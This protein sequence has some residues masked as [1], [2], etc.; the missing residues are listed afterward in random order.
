MMM[1]LL[2][3][4]GQLRTERYRDT[5][6]GCQ[7]PAVQ[8]KITDDVRR[9]RRSQLKTHVVQFH[10]AKL[11]PLL[12]CGVVNLNLLVNSSFFIIIL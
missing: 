12:R 5:E 7:K 8:Q 11:L 6:M 4:N 3:S 2:H 10:C 9:T 1:A